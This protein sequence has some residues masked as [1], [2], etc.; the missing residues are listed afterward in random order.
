MLV[1]TELVTLPTEEAGLLSLS[2][3]ADE[4]TRTRHRFEVSKGEPIFLRLPRGTVLQHGDLLRAATGE[5]LQIFAQAEPVLTIRADSELLLIRAAYYLGNRHVP[6]EIQPDYLR[7][8]DDAVLGEMLTN[9]GLIVIRETVPF[10]PE[11]GAY[12]EHSRAVE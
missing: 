6:L 10:Y 2:L 11:Q 9:L 5:L 8:S 12:G 7:I 4:R 1:F 3:T